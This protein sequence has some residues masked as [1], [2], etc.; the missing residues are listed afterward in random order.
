VGE[1]SE[2]RRAPRRAI[3]PLAVI[4]A[5]LVALGAGAAWAGSPMGDRPGIGLDVAPVIDGAPLETATPGPTPSV[6]PTPKPTSTPKP[7]SP[8]PPV[9]ID[10]DDDDDDDSD[11]ADG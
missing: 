7:V 3:W 5:G 4:V 1:A 10:D 8:P 2:N 11:D 9:D 6:T